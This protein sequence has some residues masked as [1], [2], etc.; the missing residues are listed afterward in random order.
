MSVNLSKRSSRKNINIKTTF[1][2]YLQLHW[3][4]L[5]VVRYVVCIICLKITVFT[6]YL[7]DFYKAKPSSMLRKKRYLESQTNNQFD[8][9][10]SITDTT[11]QWYLPSISPS[12]RPSVVLCAQ[13]IK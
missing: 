2:W 9:N 12:V 11:D 8:Y 3:K 5:Q 7:F 13:S 1:Q 6:I 10:A 4:H